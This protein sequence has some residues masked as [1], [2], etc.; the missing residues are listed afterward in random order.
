MSE[1]L[2]IS[3]EVLQVVIKQLA[4]GAYLND[5]GKSLTLRNVLM[6]ASNTSLKNDKVSDTM[7]MYRL[8]ERIKEANGVLNLSDSDIDDLRERGHEK[9]K[10]D[11]WVFGHM[12]KVLEG[13][14]DEAKEI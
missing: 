10:T 7:R 14:P 13:Q 11:P 3:G 8:G 9:W 2:V 12:Q 5:A 6:Y 1:Q 4:G